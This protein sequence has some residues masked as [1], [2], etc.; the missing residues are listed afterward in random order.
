MPKKICL[1]KKKTKNGL[2]QSA[3]LLV[4]TGSKNL[5]RKN[6]S[7]GTY[8]FVIHTLGKRAISIHYPE[9]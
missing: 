1:K 9:D 5:Y 4:C 3:S 8:R 2:F 6:V 7:A